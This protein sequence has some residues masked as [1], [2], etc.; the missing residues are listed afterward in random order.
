MLTSS[1]RCLIVVATSTC[2]RQS[3]TKQIEPSVR[4]RTSPMQYTATELLSMSQQELDDLFSSSPAGEIPNGQAE[5]TAI[6]ASGTR[7]SAEIA[8]LINI[9]AWQGKTFD[10][11][12]G[13]LTNR[14]LAFGLNAIVAEV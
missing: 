10:A 11:A 9:F 14:I 5:G 6:I 3:R 1:A 13:V 4:S 12:H 7:F 8:S 2:A